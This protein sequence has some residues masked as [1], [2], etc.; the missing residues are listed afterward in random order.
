MSLQPIQR[1]DKPWGYEL[2]WARTNGYAGK[3]LH[4]NRGHRL[5]L[6][7]HNQKEETILVQSGSMILVIEGEDGQ[8]GEVTLQPG[9][10]HHIAPG[11]KHRMIALEDCDVFEVS[12]NH[13]DD[14]VR[15]ED[16]YGRA[17]HAAA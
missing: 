5:S 9:Q 13:L 14:I 2:L 7:Y 8:L 4:I 12:T 10:A 1:T 16:A 15:V 11:R 3:I 6:Q 17:G